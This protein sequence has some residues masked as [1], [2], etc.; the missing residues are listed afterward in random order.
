MLFAIFILYIYLFLWLRMASDGSIPPAVQEVEVTSE[1]LEEAEKSKPHKDD[2]TGPQE[3]VE[4]EKKDVP[5]EKTNAA[6][7]NAHEK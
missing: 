2:E 7:D 1:V 4:L 5:Q 3:R 6:Q